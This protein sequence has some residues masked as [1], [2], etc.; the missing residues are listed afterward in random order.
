MLTDQDTKA[1]ISGIHNAFGIAT[2]SPALTPTQTLVAMAW[3]LQAFNSKAAEAAGRPVE[4]GGAGG[5]GACHFT[6]ADGVNHCC[7]LTLDQCNLIPGS[8]FDRG[9]LCNPP[10]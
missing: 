1:A 2:T 6:T 9:N 3:A 8:N 7:D 10:Q 5:L 4:A